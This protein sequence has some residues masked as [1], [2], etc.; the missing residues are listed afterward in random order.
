MSFDETWAI[1]DLFGHQRLAGLVSEAAIG[2]A[3]FIRVDVPG[4]DGQAAFTRYFG[5][6]AI[7]SISP[8]SE[9]VAKALVRVSNPRPVSLY[10]LPQL[11]EHTKQED[12]YDEQEHEYNDCPL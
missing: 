1:V 8:C 5:G 2:G 7:Y 10:D 4:V 3:S 11:Q 12:E 9:A 6:A